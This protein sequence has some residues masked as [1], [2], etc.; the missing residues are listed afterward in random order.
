[1]QELDLFYL[2]TEE[3]HTSCLLALREHILSFDNNI[4]EAWKFNMP[5]FLYKGNRF[6]YL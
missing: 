2:Q 4:T 3:P 5:L 6:C 1:M